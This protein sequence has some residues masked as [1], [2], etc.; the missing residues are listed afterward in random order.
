VPT[1]LITGASRGIGEV[2]ALRLARAGWDVLATVRRAPDGERL[3]GQAPAGRLRVIELDV[4]DPEGIA[5]LAAKLPEHLDGL[6]YN[7]GTVVAGPLEALS[8]EDLRRQFEVNVVGAL[9]VTNQ[10]LPRLRE[11][12]GRVV[13]LSSVSGRFSTPM[14]GAY[15]ASKFALEAMADAWRLELRAWGIAVSLIEPAMTDTDMWRTAPEQHAA[16]QDAMSS[17]HRELYARHLE[18]MRRAIPR[19]QRMA[20]PAEGVAATVERALT[21]SRPRPRYV[22]GTPARAQT[23]LLSALPPRIRDA[24]FALSTGVPRRP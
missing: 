20:R 8:P 19:M 2:T 14:T 6:V 4:T 7:A 10:T 12:R 15:N 18:G 13:L 16:T 22:V 3:A 9:A 23:L 1:V 21:D 11:A 24:A 5:G 17:A